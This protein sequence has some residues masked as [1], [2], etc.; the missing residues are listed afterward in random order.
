MMFFSIPN[1]SFDVA[2]GWRVYRQKS[3]GPQGWGLHDPPTD[4]PHRSQCADCGGTAH[5]KRSVRAA[6]FP[7][8]GLDC[9]SGGVGGANGVRTVFDCGPRNLANSFMIAQRSQQG[10]FRLDCPSSV[11]SVA[12]GSQFFRF[13]EW[14]SSSCCAACSPEFAI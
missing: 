1:E 13:G 4:R 11:H 6:R 10:G 7:A 2:E 14:G 12:E 8:L 5:R 3:I 9:S